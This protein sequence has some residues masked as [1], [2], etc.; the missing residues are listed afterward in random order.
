MC[1][2]VEVAYKLF[3][4]LFTSHGATIGCLLKDICELLGECKLLVFMVLRELSWALCCNYAF[5]ISIRVP[6]SI[7]LLKYS[8]GSWQDA[9][10]FQ[11]FNVATTTNALTGVGGKL[12]VTHTLVTWLDCN[13]TSIQVL[14]LLS[15]NLISI[16]VLDKVHL[17]IVFKVS[18]CNHELRLMLTSI[19]ITYLVGCDQYLTWTIGLLIPWDPGRVAL[20]LQMLHAWCYNL[21]TV[22]HLSFCPSARERKA[23]SVDAAFVF[24]SQ[25]IL[26]VVHS[27]IWIMLI[28]LRSIGCLQFSWDPDGSNATH[29]L[30][31][32]P[33]FKKGGML[34]TVGPI[35][36]GPT[37]LYDGLCYKEARRERNGASKN[38]YRN[39]HCLVSTSR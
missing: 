11:F 26:Q 18:Q 13:L 6:I 14:V 3:E 31:G 39:I 33:N 16:F 21:S 28:W 8:T 22:C 1:M 20:D 24:A 9:S 12:E 38:Y 4:K 36:Y 30:E 7:P 17:M 35:V 15:G 23:L 32:K 37:Q 19:G 27:V 5:R 34:G 2:L 25:R 10:L 29:R